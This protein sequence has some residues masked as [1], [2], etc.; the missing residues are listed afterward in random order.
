MTNDKNSANTYTINESLSKLVKGTGF[1]II[2]L[3]IVNIFNLIR[4]V[5]IARTWTESDVGIFS[6]ANTVFNICITISALGMSEGVVRS[7]AH[8]RR[9][10]EFDKIQKFI[11]TS[12]LLSL[13]VSV[14]LGLI[15]FF[16]SEFIAVDIF[17]ETSLILPLKIISMATPFFT[18]NVKIV[19][20][21]RGFEQIKPLAYFKFILESALF[22]IFVSVIVVLNYP[23]IYV[24]YA[25]I[26]SVIIITIVLIIYTISKSSSFSFFPI[27]SIVSPAAKELIY[28]SLPLLGTAVIG[29]IIMWTDTLMLGGIKSAGDV[30][31]YRAV[32]PFPTIIFFPLSALLITFVPVFSGLYA[33]G[34]LK[35]MKSN[36]L[37]LTKWICIV[38]LPLFVLFFLFPELTIN[39]L[40]GSDY[41]PSA[42]VLRILSL[43]CIINNFVGPCNATLL[44]LGKTRFIMFTTISAATLNIILN[45][46]LIPSYSF[47]GAAIASGATLIFVNILRILKV[48]SLSKIQPFS[49]N[50]IKTTLSSVIFIIPIYYFSQQ[51]LP[52]NWWSLVLLFILFYI[53]YIPSVLLTKS[54]DEDDMKMLT[55]IERKTGIKITRI[56]KFLSRFIS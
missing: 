31:F 28:F 29:L 53:I 22:M 38:T 18:V 41:L 16:Y 44:A 51:F 52:Y 56:K 9:K 39:V 4:R 43:A 47:I 35:E 8:S 7:I 20:I 21:F 42:N 48:Y 15:L 10:N 6:L 3:L 5:L 40:I 54:L 19:S 25:F 33:K 50:L 2:S 27:K 32:T 55:A 37:I 49:S 26:F 13:L 23:F 34:R 1:I 14:I 11:V 12:V 46:L 17:H 45:V 30:G 36:Y 24:F